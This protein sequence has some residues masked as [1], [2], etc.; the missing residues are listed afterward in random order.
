MELV[1]LNKNASLYISHKED[2][3]V[4]S[5]R[6]ELPLPASEA[7]A[8]STELR[9]RVEKFYHSCMVK[10]G[11]SVI[12]MGKG[13]RVQPGLILWSPD[14]HPHYQGWQIAIS[15]VPVLHK[16]GRNAVYSESVLQREQ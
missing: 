15:Y 3:I 14:F 1:S 4:P 16:V 13:G 2:R 12:P 11:K 8:L 5:G 7:D 6:L 10:V 9:G